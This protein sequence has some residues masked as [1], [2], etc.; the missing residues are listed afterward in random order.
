MRTGQVDGVLGG[1]SGAATHS[2]VRAACTSASG[3]DSAR[4]GYP[5][6]SSC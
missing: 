1:D 3:C 6:S 4:S 2:T 5:R